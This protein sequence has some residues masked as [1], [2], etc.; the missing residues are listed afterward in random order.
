MDYTKVPVDELEVY[1]NKYESCELYQMFEVWSYDEACLR[2]M[3]WRL[4]SI[5]E[6]LRIMGYLTH[7]GIGLL[8]TEPMLEVIFENNNGDVFRTEYPYR[9]FKEV[10][11]A[12]D[13]WTTTI[14]IDLNSQI[15]AR[16]VATR[17]PIKK[18][19]RIFRGPKVDLGTF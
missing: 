6:R 4:Q 15:K 2:V 14:V 16:T 5:L 9:A 19:E 11:Y 12:L 1:L 17:E 10:G 3:K 8:D 7:V 13:V 18:N